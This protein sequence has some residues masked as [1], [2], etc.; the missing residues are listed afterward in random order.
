MFAL[1]K[2]GSARMTAK[3]LTSKIVDAVKT[4]TLWHRGVASIRGRIE[5]QIKLRQTLIFLFRISSLRE[6]IILLTYAA[7]CR[8]RMKRF[9]SRP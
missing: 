7:V 8:N 3:P 5:Y 6:M 4:G 2:P 9:H 1:Y